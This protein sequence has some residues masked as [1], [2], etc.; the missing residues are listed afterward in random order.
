MRRVLGCLL[1]LLAACERA[2][3]TAVST[4]RRGLWNE[5]ADRPQLLS[6]EL[7]RGTGDS[8]AVARAYLESNGAEFHL[9]LNGLSLERIDLKKGLAGEY[10]RFGQRQLVDGEVLPVFDGQVIVLV[11]DE[12]GTRVIRAVN[13]EQREGAATVKSAGDLGRAAMRARA[14]SETEGA[15]A[16][17]D[18]VTLE[19][20]VFVTDAGLARVAWRVRVPMAEA[21]PPHQWELMLDAATGDVLSRRDRLR[22]VQGTGSVFDMNAVAS[23]NDLTMVDD[24]DSVTPELDAARFMVVLENLD[25]SGFTRGTWAD[26]RTRDAGARVNS[27]TLDFSFSRNNLGFEQTN[28]YFHLDRSQRRIQALGFTNVNARVQVAVINAQGADNSFYDPQTL[29]LSFGTGGVDDAEDGDI[30]SHEY[31]HSIQD[32]QVPDFGNGDEGAMGEGFGDYLAA[33]FG[34][35]LPLDAGHPQLSDPA[36]VG[37]WDGVSYSNDTPPCLRR[38]DGVKHY[39]EKATDEVH[40]DGEMWSAALWRARATL[41]ADVMDRLVIESHFLLGTSSS[42]F[43]AAAAL[44]TVDQTLN[45]GANEVVLRRAMVL[46]GLSRVVSAPSDAGYASS[47]AVA[48]GPRRDSLGNYRSNADEVKRLRVPGAEG[49]QLHFARIDFEAHA[50]CV[51]GKC[52]N[53]YLT[54]AEGDLFQVLGGTFDAGFSSVAIPGDTVDVRLV[55]DSSQSR[56]GYHIDRIDV[57]GA[58]IDAGLEYDGGIDPYDAGMP[59]VVVDSGVPDS[60]VRDAGVDAGVSDAGIR[61]AGQAFDAG[62][63]EVDAGPVFGVVWLPKLGTETLSPAANR[64]C[65]C[66]ADGGVINALVAMMG[67]LLIRRRR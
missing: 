67:L 12:A 2:P 18:E 65:G 41:G 66:S 10:V 47:L 31:G 1:L 54:N 17:S 19:R 57:L 13:L 14:L 8:E 48:V 16:L 33:S 64:G 61:D 4:E 24:N 32:N 36:C 45:A 26:V 29:R 30:V 27:S 42:F 63:G 43:T 55:S 6:G 51:A 49:L 5:R 25:G 9:A 46:Q 59:M 3:S 60:G 40:D 22:F 11:R 56:F 44:V 62:P 35:V 34:Q 15:E 39:P 7:A 23:T 38:V 28:T 50:S 37:D 58:L 52:D 53:L 21:T 20:G